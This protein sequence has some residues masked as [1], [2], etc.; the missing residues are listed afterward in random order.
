MLESVKSGN[1]LTN[2][3]P[4][5]TKSWWPLVEDVFMSPAVADMSS[6]LLEQAISH[7]DCQSLSIDGTFRICF[8]LLGQARFDAPKSVRDTFPF[9]GDA[10]VTRVIS[11]RGR[12]GSVLGLLPAADE[13][14]GELVRCIK[15]SLP[16]CAWDQIQHIA[17]DNPSAKLHEDFAAAF[18][19]FRGL[20]L[21]PTHAAMRYEEGTGGRKTA[22]SMLL[23]SFMAKFAAHDVEVQGNIWGPFFTGQS[24]ETLSPQENR[25]RDQIL[26]SSMPKRRAKRVLEEAEKLQV[27]PTR[28]QFLEALAALSSEHKADMSRKVEG[29][30]ITIAKTLHVLAAPEKVG[31]LLN[32]LRYRAGLTLQIRT[33]LPSG[34]TSNEAVHSELNAWF[35]Q[36]QSMHRST[37]MLKLR[38]LQLGKLLAH[39]LSLYSPTARQMP[40]VQVLARRLGTPLWTKATWGQWAGSVSHGDLPLASQRQVEEEVVAGCGR[41]RPASRQRK[42]T[43]FTLERGQRVR[44]TGVHKRPAKTRAKAS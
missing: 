17:T 13:S 26:S 21:D 35:R 12:T 16:A 15:E 27:W 43:P 24:K 30:R 38:I 34:T 36:I 4:T 33:L 7:D 20:S 10:A 29:T 25:L 18:P 19:H 11:I 40:A 8:S 39:S 3:L 23:R 28:I 9:H 37:L 5:H 44:R 31:W 1:E 41:K 14:S 32:G 6:A 2:L 42:K 22:G